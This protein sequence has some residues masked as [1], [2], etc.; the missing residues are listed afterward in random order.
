MEFT[1]RYRIE[2]ARDVVWEKMTNA[3]VLRRAIPGCQ[4][5]E[6]TSEGR[7]QATLSTNIGPVKAAINGDVVMEEMQPPSSYRLR[8]KGGMA[9]FVTDVDMLEDG[10]AATIVTFNARSKIGGPLA[11]LGGRMIKRVVGRLVNRFFVKLG[12]VMSVDVAE[13]ESESGA[14]AVA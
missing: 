1:G 13:L 3:D 8:G 7:F 11:N 4:K 10:P 6:T 2:A 14:Q 9:G 12:A 5:L